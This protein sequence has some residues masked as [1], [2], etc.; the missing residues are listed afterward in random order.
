[1]IK[2]SPNRWSRRDFLNAGM[3]LGGL[4]VL[5]P[6]AAW[7]SDQI[8]PRVAAI[9]AK[10]MGIDTHNHIDVPLIKAEVPGPVAD[11]FGEMKKS[12]LAAICMTFAVDYQKLS[13]ADDGYERFMNGLD[14]MDWQLKNNGMKRALTVA[15]LQAAHRKHQPTVIQSVEG[16]HFLNGKAERLAEAY[17]R[18]LRHLHYYMTATHQFRWAMC[19]PTRYNGED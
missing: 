7:A 5:N 1:M 19:L 15:D 17:Q 16:G 10:T 13:N 9:V 2:D 4:M 14:A 12:G 6:F 8:D 3:A 18:G 11:L